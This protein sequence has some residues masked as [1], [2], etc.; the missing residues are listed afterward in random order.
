MKTIRKNVFETNSSSTH[1]ICITPE[2]W[3]EYG[4]GLDFD[5]PYKEIT[6]EEVLGS[7]W[8]TKVIKVETS[9][10][11]KRGDGFFLVKGPLEKCQFLLSCLST[12]SNTFTTY[13]KGH[14]LSKIQCFYK[15]IVKYFETTFD[16]N[17]L[18]VDYSQKYG[19]S[20]FVDWLIGHYWEKEEKFSEEEINKIV[21]KVITN[22]NII[23]IC[24]S[25]E[26][27]PFPEDVGLIQIEDLKELL[28]E[29]NS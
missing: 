15:A 27:G 13:I 17:Y 25:D 24:H 20:N 10:Y 2:G 12:Y 4:H 21:T 9:D 11:Y 7:K 19:E 22:D 8:N 28:N 23:F 14:Q 29:N 6:V 26:S 16:T 5:S 3:N 18:K 1:S